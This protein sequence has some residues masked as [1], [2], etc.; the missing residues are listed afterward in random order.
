MKQK[1]DQFKVT[2]GNLKV[3]ELVPRMMTTI[4][5]RVKLRILALEFMME[6]RR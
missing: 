3:L 5:Y 1:R 2:S 6:Q 4:K